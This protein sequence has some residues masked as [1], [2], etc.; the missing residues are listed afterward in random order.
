[1]GVMGEAFRAFAK[2]LLEDP[3]LTEEELNQALSLVQLCWNLALLPEKQREET[4][5]KVKPQFKMDD[6]DFE[7]FRQAVIMPMIRRQH[8]MFPNMLRRGGASASNP[9]VSQQSHEGAGQQGGISS[10]TG[11]NDPC[12]C[13]SGKKYKKCCGR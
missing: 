9:A 4:I 8:E 2:P 6:E 1:M 13:K 12:P 7:E 5:E 10:E 3:E 11:R